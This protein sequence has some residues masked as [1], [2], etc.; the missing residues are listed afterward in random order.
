MKSFPRSLRASLFVV[1]LALAG[2]GG[3][4]GEGD[5]ESAEKPDLIP[6]KTTGSTWYG[7][8]GGYVAHV[9]NQ[10][11]GT[12]V[13]CEVLVTFTGASGGDVTVSFSVPALAP[14]TMSPA[15]SAPYPGL[16]AT[17]YMIQVDVMNDVD[18]SDETNNE[19]SEEILI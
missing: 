10:G 15:L 11:A 18:E 1:T 17:G 8:T 2:C 9:F 13:P 4:N 6:V 14:G 19:D 7:T 12:S 16:S 5:P 3:G